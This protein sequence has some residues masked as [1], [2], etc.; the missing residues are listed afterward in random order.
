MTPYQLGKVCSLDI[1]SNGL[2]E[3]SI[4]FKKGFPVKLKESASLW[5]I[6]ITDLETKITVNI[7]HTD[8]GTTREWLKNELTK[9]DTIVL[10][11]GIKFDLPLLFLFNVI[12]YS[13]GYIGKKDR[14]FDK[15]VNILDTLIISRILNPSRLHGHSLKSWGKR[16]NNHKIEFRE[17]LIELGVLSTKS[18][19]GEEFTKFHPEMLIYCDQDTILT[20]DVFENLW[21]EVLISE[22]NAIKKEHKLADLSINR[23]IFGFDFN[24]QYA[25]E[26]ILDLDNKLNNLRDIVNPILPEKQLN[27][28]DLNFYTPPKNQTKKNGDISS[29][30]ISFCNLHN[31]SLYSDIDSKQVLFEFEG[32]VFDVGY[33]KPIKEYKPGDISDIDHVK[34]YLIELGWNP[35]EWRIRDLTKS[36]DKKS[37]PF[38]KRVAALKRYISETYNGKYKDHRAKY[39]KI[40]D[41]SDKSEFMAVYKDL[42]SKLK[43]D[44]PVRVITSPATKV[45][46]T[47]E[48]CPNLL[49]LGDKVEFA[50]HF[51]LY[52]TF[53]HRRSCIADKEYFIEDGEDNVPE[54]G[55]L[56]SV[57][58]DGRISTPAIEIGATSNRYKH[59]VVANVPRATSVYGKEM[60]SLFGAGSDYYQLGFDFSS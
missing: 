7:M 30:M 54:K 18:P 20:G 44:Y 51:G 48:L 31:I 11:N 58:E 10:H 57:R 38:E 26:C 35:I 56:H 24:L 33:Q 40:K 9:Y 34:H 3:D 2:L 45:G 21:L 47:K 29:H 28:S 15:E 17:R 46:V 12:D 60:R 37:I 53:K 25:K 23:E 42:Y 49:A 19:A 41:S 13:I 4:D 59:S 16:L 36:A 14:I 27:Q 6:S 22:H 32:N 52:T 55:Y 50:K 8:T 39:L 1:E 5:C 43:D